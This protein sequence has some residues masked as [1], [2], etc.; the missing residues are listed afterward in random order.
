MPGRPQTICLC[1]ETQFDTVIVDRPLV[2][3]TLLQLY[4]Q[5]PARAIFS[6]SFFTSRFDTL[7]M[8]TQIR[9]ERRGDIPLM[10]G[11]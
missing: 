6:W 4:N 8:E 11:T 5:L 1:L 9:L 10:K 7:V 3:K 2:L